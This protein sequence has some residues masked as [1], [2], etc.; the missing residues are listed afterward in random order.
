MNLNNI[1]IAVFDMAGT[2]IDEGHTVYQS[3][4]EALAEVEINISAE[5]VFRQIGG[6]NK[7]DG[8]QQLINQSKPD[9]PDNTLK[10]AVGAFL[11]ILEEKYAR[12]GAVKEMQ[13]ASLLFAQLKEQRVN[14]ALDTGYTRAIAEML[15]EIVG[16]DE[17]GLVDFMI[18]SEEVE[19]G[20]PSPLMIHKVMEYFSITDPG[21]VIKIGDTK[22]DIQEGINARCKYVIGVASSN[23][24][25]ADLLGFGATHVVENLTELLEQVDLSTS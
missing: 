7:V 4:A 15:L 18:S 2:T 8:I 9:T 3:V 17:H 12:P 5:E 19:S 25:T 13:G 22:A 1:K 23:Y 16:W 14:V 11:R 20:R 10:T 21:Q 6:M 24:S